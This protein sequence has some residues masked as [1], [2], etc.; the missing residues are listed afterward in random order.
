MANMSLFNFYQCLFQMDEIKQEI[1]KQLDSTRNQM[2]EERKGQ[3]ESVKDVGLKN[4]I[5]FT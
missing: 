3:L 5:S 4:Y 2:E 1:Q